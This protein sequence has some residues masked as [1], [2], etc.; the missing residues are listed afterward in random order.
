MNNKKSPSSKEA[1][2]NRLYDTE[3]LIQE[4]KKEIMRRDI[5][6]I[7]LVV[8]AVILSTALSKI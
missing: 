1:G 2:D 8:I 6:D 5:R 3:W 7:S 4:K